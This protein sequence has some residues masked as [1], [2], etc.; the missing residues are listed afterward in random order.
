MSLDDLRSLRARTAAS[1]SDCRAALA[2]TGDLGAAV[3]WLEARGLAPSLAAAAER[4]RVDAPPPSDEAFWALWAEDRSRPDVV[5]DPDRLAAY[6]SAAAAISEDERANIERELGLALS[7][8]PKL[9]VSVGRR[10]GARTLDEWLHLA[11][12]SNHDLAYRATLLELG[13]RGQVLEQLRQSARGVKAAFTLLDSLGELGPD[14]WSLA[15]PGTT[16]RTARGLA[17]VG[18][19]L[20]LG[21][22][23]PKEGL[24]I[25]DPMALRSARPLALRAPGSWRVVRV[26][27]RV[28]GEERVAAIHALA[29]PPWEHGMDYQA[30]W[31][32][33]ATWEQALDLDGRPAWLRTDTATGA[34]TTP[35]VAA[36]CPPLPELPVQG[37]KR[38]AKG[39]VLGFSTGFGDGAWPVYLARDQQ[40]APIALSVDLMGAPSPDPGLR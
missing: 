28:D 27:A 14:R 5:P 20:K 19:T 3:S 1:L 25:A 32:S 39:T 34:I 30:G 17:V 36:V 31:D 10:I 26:S 21:T 8:R 24:V 37:Q 16:L 11:L 9:A 40:G 6:Q 15:R 13:E 18:E 23:R 7:P 22:L 12:R 33:I 29:K 4:P 35:A 38:L 2:E